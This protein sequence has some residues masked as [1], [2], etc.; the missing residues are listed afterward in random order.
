[1][2]KIH[3]TFSHEPN[4]CVD[5]A[6]ILTA[7]QQDKTDSDKRMGQ[8]KSW[9]QNF[10]QTAYITEDTARLEEDF[11]VLDALFSDVADAARQIPEELL[12]YYFTSADPSQLSPGTILAWMVT[13]GMTPGDFPEERREQVQVRTAVCVLPGN[14]N[15]AFEQLQ[16]FPELMRLLADADFPAEIKWMAA[17][18]AMRAQEME[19]EV[20]RLLTAPMEAYKRH[21]PRLQPLFDRAVG[22]MERH[23]R[24]A[25]SLQAVLSERYHFGLDSEALTIIPGAG[26]YNGLSL[27]AVPELMQN[28]DG[29]Y[30][31]LGCMYDGLLDKRTDSNIPQQLISR[32]KALDDRQ[33]LKILWE[34]RSG[35]LCGAD[36][37]AL[38]GLSPATVS[39]HMNLLCQN[40]FVTVEKHGVRIEYRLSKEGTN[41]LLRQLRQ[42][43]GL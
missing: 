21:L 1:M 14:D 3:C 34:L 36:L 38:T 37:C 10:L 19:E 11:A 2:G 28:P 23:L 12:S 13:V 26:Q 42:L 24:E 43:F 8:P 6:M 31:H 22:E 32:C 30:F 33:R 39:H 16:T 41:R 29:L 4:I 20:S 18:V 5:T 25:P 17:D 9:L 7:L 27:W 40:D 35:P 15:A